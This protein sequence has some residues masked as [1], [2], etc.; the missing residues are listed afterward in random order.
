MQS[1]GRMFG[2]GQRGNRKGLHTGK[3]VWWGTGLSLKGNP[4]FEW[5][6]R[7]SKLFWWIGK[8]GCGSGGKSGISKG[9]VIFTQRENIDFFNELNIE[10]ACKSLTIAKGEYKPFDKSKNTLIISTLS[11]GLHNDLKESLRNNGFNCQ[12]RGC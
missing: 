6:A 11:T 9:N 3:A 7:E 4:L 10:I 5:G 2:N 1:V 12:S 8:Y